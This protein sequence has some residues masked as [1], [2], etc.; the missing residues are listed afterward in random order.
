MPDEPS[1]TEN[2]VHG[3][4]GSS[5]FSGINPNRGTGSSSSNCNGNSNNSSNRVSDDRATGR[6]DLLVVSLRIALCDVLAVS[7]TPSEQSPFSDFGA[8]FGFGIFQVSFSFT[9][10]LTH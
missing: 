5:S 1:R 10:S 7:V 9:H 3:I 2:K 8:S 6:S 4:A